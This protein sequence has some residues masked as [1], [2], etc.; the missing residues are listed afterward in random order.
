MIKPFKAS[1]ILLSLLKHLS[2]SLSLPYSLDCQVFTKDVGFDQH[3]YLD[4]HHLKCCLW[5]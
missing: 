3:L 1:F 2:S 4:L 5:I